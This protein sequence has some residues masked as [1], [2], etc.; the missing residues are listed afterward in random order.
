MT[1]I[2]ELDLDERVASLVRAVA[3]MQATLELLHKA[4]NAQAHATN[5]G[6]TRAS[7]AGAGSTRSEAEAKASEQ[8]RRRSASG[9][10]RRPDT[11]PRAAKADSASR[12]RFQRR[13][14]RACHADAVVQI[15]QHEAVGA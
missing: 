2:N 5:E 12:G 8:Q 3:S 7:A 6:P 11:A 15:G 4:A 9:S 1:P 13:Q 14:V 10:A